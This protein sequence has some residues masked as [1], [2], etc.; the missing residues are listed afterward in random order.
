MSKDTDT[1]SRDMVIADLPFNISLPYSEGHVINA[2]EAK[3][4]NQTRC[5]NISNAMRKKIKELADE[6]GEYS[7]EAVKAAQKLV[8]DYDAEYV[9]TLAS[10]GGGRTKKD[11]IQKEAESLARAAITAALKSQGRKVGDVDKEKLAEK[12]ASV[13]E[14]E[15][16]LKQAKANVAARSK[17]IEGLDI[18]I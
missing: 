12:I 15:A 5:E 11:P 8:A 3:T 14:N 1:A 18:T 7:A 16:I 4:L 13:A 10:A 2:A 17:T 6:A 9:F